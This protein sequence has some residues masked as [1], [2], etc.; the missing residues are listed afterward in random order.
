MIVSWYQFALFSDTD[1]IGDSGLTED[2][3]FINELN[4]ELDWWEYQ[5][6]TWLAIG[7]HHYCLFAYTWA[8]NLSILS[9]L[10]VKVLSMYVCTYVHT[11]VHMLYCAYII[12]IPLTL[13]L[14][15]YL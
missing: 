15:L 5:E 1:L 2:N 10:E 11:C 13:G 14:G 12:Y 3:D 6:E 7:R 4:T 9:D 8:D